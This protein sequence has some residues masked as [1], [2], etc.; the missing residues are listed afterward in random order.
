MRHLAII[1]V[2]LSVCAFAP[3]AAAQDCNKPLKL[4]SSLAMTDRGSNNVVTIPVSLNG[5]EKQFLLDT[6]GF[7]T[8]VA[9]SV[10]DELKLSQ[11][12]RGIEIYA[13][14]GSVS[15][16]VVFVPDFA[17]GPLHTKNYEIPV[18][19]NKGFD[20]IFSPLAFHN[21]DFEMDFTTHKLNMF[22]NDHCDGKVIYWPHQAVGVVPFVVGNSNH[23]VV[24]VTVDGHELKATVD[25]GATV[26]TISR[27]RA[28]FIFDLQPN[29]PDMTVIGHV[30]DDQN[31]PIFEHHFK[32]LTFGDIT[33][34]NP[35]IHIYTDIVNK[36]ADHS[37]SVENR[38]KSVS[39]DL[40]LPDAIIGMDVLRKLHIYLAIKENRLYLTEASTPVPAATDAPK[41]Q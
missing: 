5:V 22:L 28:E 14:D 36:N 7:F 19:P 8:Q 34:T 25:T 26:S 15:R 29:S 12:Q 13:S 32:T 10:A 20:G 30:G 16:T 37:Q 1:A 3:P 41:P 39:A 33:V 40:T 4:I 2:L 21:V 24:P 35:H 23:I 9:P 31:A 38:A 11:T 18:S 27:N 6:G 17:I